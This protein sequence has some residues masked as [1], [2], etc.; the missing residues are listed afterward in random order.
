MTIFSNGKSYIKGVGKHSTKGETSML[1]W[2][3]L[4]Y[5]GKRV[6]GRQLDIDAEMYIHL[7]YDWVMDAGLIYCGY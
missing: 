4:V 7:G 1:I 5:R 2:I 6:F 3:D